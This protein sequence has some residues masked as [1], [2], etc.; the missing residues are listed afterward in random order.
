MS[1]NCER[2]AML[3]RFLQI[4][5]LRIIYGSA[6]L[7]IGFMLLG[8]KYMKTIVVLFKRHFA[9]HALTQ[10]YFS[11]THYVCNMFVNEICL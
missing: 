3:K 6:S 2:S 5:T 8:E 10:K 1:L 4:L 11:V 9:K 7:M